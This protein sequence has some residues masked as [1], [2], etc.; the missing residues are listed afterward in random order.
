M[1]GNRLAW[2]PGVCFIEIDKK[3]YLMAFVVAISHEKPAAVA[4][5]KLPPLL[6]LTTSSSSLLLPLSSR[7]SPVHKDEQ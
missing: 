4:V 5:S 7:L 2:C 1:Y 3:I 6:L